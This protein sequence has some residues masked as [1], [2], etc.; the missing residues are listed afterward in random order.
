MAEFETELK[1]SSDIT[2]HIKTYKAKAKKKSSA[3]RNRWVNGLFVNFMLQ[4]TTITHP[5]VT[6]I[7]G[8]YNYL[9]SQ[10]FMRDTILSAWFVVLA[11]TCCGFYSRTTDKC[12]RKYYE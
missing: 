11:S 5:Q 12:I 4:R 10:K 1:Q 3:K 6:T 8:F 2:E 7:R 9:L